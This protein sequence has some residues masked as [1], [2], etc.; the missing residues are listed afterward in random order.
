M[1]AGQGRAG[2]S[3]RDFLRSAPRSRGATLSAV[4][5]QAFDDWALNDSR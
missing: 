1:A 3:R 4:S 5:R 2:T